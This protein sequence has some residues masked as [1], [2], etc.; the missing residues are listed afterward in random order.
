MKTIKNTLWLII[1]LLPLVGTAQKNKGEETAESLRKAIL[2]YEACLYQFSTPLEK[3][4]LNVGERELDAAV[5]LKFESGN[6][7]VSDI[8]ELRKLSYF[9]GAN[10]RTGSF[11]IAD[12]KSIGDVFNPREIDFLQTH[13]YNRPGTFHILGHGI[14]DHDNISTGEIMI[15]GH[16]VKAAEMA[17]AMKELLH[18]YQSI[19]TAR[20]EP[21][22]VVVHSCKAGSASPDSFAA[23]LSAELA[24]LS[25]KIYVIGAPDN[26]YP[27]IDVKTGYYDEKIA[28]N[29]GNAVNEAVK[30][31]NWNIFYDGKFVTEGLPSF[32]DTISLIK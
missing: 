31:K 28:S 9:T 2:E 4:T 29:S 24:K 22:T 10:T 25:S 6:F 19:V 14:V 27:A 16:N 1:A 15:D 23:Q 7:H 18:S 13:S 30:G 26:I 20:N 8:D 17:Q 3:A 11:S 12:F 5:E 32:D 21:F